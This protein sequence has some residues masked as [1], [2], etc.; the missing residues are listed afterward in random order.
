[1]AEYIS[2]NAL[3]NHICWWLPGEKKMWYDI[4]DQQAVVRIV[5][6]FQCRF[7]TGMYCTLM[8]HE[9]GPEWFCSEGWKKDD[10]LE[11]D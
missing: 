10:L 6:C 7:F 8:K 3:K 11:R 9:V 1:M 2:K 4:I 5:R